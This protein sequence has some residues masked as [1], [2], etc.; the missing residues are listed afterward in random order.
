MIALVLALGLAGLALVVGLLLAIQVNRLNHKMADVTIDG[1]IFDALRRVDDDLA[2]LEGVVAAMRP[3]VQSLHE[4]LPGAL[5][6]AA[7]V[8]YDA[9]DDR[10]GKLSRSIALLNERGDGLVLTVL[11]GRTETFFFCKMVRG[12]RGTEALS[13]EEEQA[14]AQA[15]VG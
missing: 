9:T 8:V 10:A 7:V 11:S 15:R 6:Y 1:D 13:P 2:K 5:R 12:G 3:V 14:V 4:R